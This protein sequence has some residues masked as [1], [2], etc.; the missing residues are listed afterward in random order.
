MFRP[1]EQT[2]YDAAERG[3]TVYDLLDRLID[4][5]GFNEIETRVFHQTVDRAKQA[6]IFG[7][8]ATKLGE[9]KPDV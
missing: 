4:K 6:A 1:N 2:I 8:V 9:E 5:A 7:T 3:W